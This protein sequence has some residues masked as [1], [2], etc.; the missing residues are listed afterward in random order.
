MNRTLLVITFDLQLTSLTNNFSS[1]VF[2][3]QKTVSAITNYYNITF[4]TI[5]EPGEKQGSLVIIFSVW[6]TMLGSAVV[7][8]PWAY[9]QAG[10]V[11][12]T[13]ISF[14][15]FIISYYTCYL[16]IYTA[17]KDSDFFDTVKRYYGK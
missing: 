10:L 16:I 8:L 11:L 13:F 15:S 4:F 1:S 3:S 7:S 5:A 17:R 6:K 2:P 12:G 9:Q 14:T